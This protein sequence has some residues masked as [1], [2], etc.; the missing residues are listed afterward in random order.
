MKLSVPLMEKKR[1]KGGRDS[2]R[3]TQSN[4]I[5][6]EHGFTVTRRALKEIFQLRLQIGLAEGEGGLWALNCWGLGRIRRGKL[7]LESY[8]AKVGWAKGRK[9]K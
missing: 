9:E 1:V 4:S 8:W 5:N 6:S 7:G 3:H 2:G